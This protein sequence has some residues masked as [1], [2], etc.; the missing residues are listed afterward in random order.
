MRYLI[1]YA[2]NSE[3]KFISHLDLMRTIQRV[4]RRAEIEVEFSKGFNPHMALSIAQPLAVGVHSIGD[5]L[6]LVLTSSMNEEELIEKLNNNAPI[7]V[8]FL[9]AVAVPKIEG[10]KSLQSMAAIDAARYTI[11]I[12]VNKKSIGDSEIQELLKKDKWEIN[13]IG[14]SGERIVDLKPQIKEIKFWEKDEELIIKVLVSCGSKENLSP[15]LLSE[16]IISNT[17]FAH[18]DKFIDI[19]REEMY[20]YKDSEYLTLSEFFREDSTKK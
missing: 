12:P 10:R 13:K 20:V 14:K 8:K 19:K 9:E 11:K 7:G 15:Q 3:I 1:K 17:S 4:V 6:D 18:K 2:K 16:F 5:Y